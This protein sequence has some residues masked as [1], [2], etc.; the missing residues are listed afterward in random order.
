MRRAPGRGGI[1]ID[2]AQVIGIEGGCGAAAAALW[3]VPR[4]LDSSTS[5]Q[6]V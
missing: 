4:S 3:P 1:Q 6:A 5:D 2:Q